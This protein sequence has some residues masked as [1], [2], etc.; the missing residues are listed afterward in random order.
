MKTPVQ[1]L[2][3]RKA[4]VI[5]SGQGE[6]NFDPVAWFGF[7]FLQETSENIKCI[8]G[9]CFYVYNFSTEIIIF[10]ESDIYILSSNNKFTRHIYLDYQNNRLPVGV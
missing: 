8:R 9:L 2:V 5:V 6:V 10:P 4:E 7:K 1:W 3:C